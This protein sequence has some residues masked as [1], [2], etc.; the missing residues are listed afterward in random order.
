MNLLHYIKGNRKGKN[1]HRIEYEAMKDPFLQDAIDGYDIVKG[2]H[3][4]E[5]SRLQENIIQKTSV[6][7]KNTSIWWVA[8]SLLVL[9]GIGTL[10]FMPSQKEVYISQE[11][12]GIPEEQVFFPSPTSRLERE[13]FTEEKRGTQKNSQEKTA[14]IQTPELEQKIKVNRMINDEGFHLSEMEDTKE[15]ITYRKETIAEE[16]NMEKSSYS[17]YFQKGTE[18]SIS[19]KASGLMQEEFAISLPPSSSDDN[20]EATSPDIRQI[21]GKVV[22]NNGVAI[23]G[24]VVKQNN[25]QNITITDIDG[26]FSLPIE[27]TG[28]DVL[29]IS[30]IGY[31]TEETK[32][33]EESQLLIALREDYATLDEVIVTGHGNIREQKSLST[34]SSEKK[35]EKKVISHPEPTMGKT[36]FRNY[37]DKNVKQP[38]DDFC[39]NKKGSVVLS[40]YVGENGLLQNIV[41]KQSLCPS[42]DQL[43]ID[44]LEK[45]GTWYPVQ[46][47][48]EITIYFPGK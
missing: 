29:T 40:F 45:S 23:I 25:T 14:S 20:I 43:A 11:T 3:E 1:A 48:G 19:V 6:R 26:N 41:I 39:K 27:A 15:I 46:V 36:E 9:T 31:Q 33:K 37:L 30:Y 8:A 28:K 21:K 18:D 34:G 10:L 16:I 24:A 44:I 2:N 5:I 32:I 7:K 17:M 12:V 38:T 47:P 35:I 13:I 4:K 42:A 22:D